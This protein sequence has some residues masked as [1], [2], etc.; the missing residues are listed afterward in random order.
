MVNKD[1]VRKQEEQL[2]TMAREVEITDGEYQEEQLLNLQLSNEHNTL[3]TN[4]SHVL[5]QRNSLL[6]ECEGLK[7]TISILNAQIQSVVSSATTEQSLRDEIRSQLNQIQE[8][9]Q[10]WTQSFQ[11]VEQEC[12]QRRR[13]IL[14][15]TQFPTRSL[16]KRKSSPR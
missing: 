12:S 6:L 11:A 3:I 13:E 2:D 16:R 15:D 4:L 5:N 14:A 7:D 8:Q 10:S 1:T 9:W